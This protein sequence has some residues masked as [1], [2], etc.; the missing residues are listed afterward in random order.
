MAAVEISYLEVLALKKL[1]LI[2]AALAKSLKDNAAKRE[3]ETLLRVLMD[4]TVRADLA[5]QSRR[6][7]LSQEGE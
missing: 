1:A 5:V 2:N 6:A 4:V 3:Q 7:A